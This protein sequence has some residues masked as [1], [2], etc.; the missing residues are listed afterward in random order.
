MWIKGKPVCREVLISRY[1]YDSTYP[2]SL[3]LFHLVCLALIVSASAIVHDGMSIIRESRK[4][5]DRPVD[6]SRR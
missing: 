6:G 2:I 3:S 5:N 1:S 4:F